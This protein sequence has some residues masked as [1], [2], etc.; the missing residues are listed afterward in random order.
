MLYLWPYMLFFSWPIIAQSLLQG[1]ISVCKSWSEIPRKVLLLGTVTNAAMA[2]IHY[3]T[4]V[5]PFTLADNRHYTFYVFRI[6][7][8]RPEIKYLAAPIYVL[9]AYAV[10][11]ALGHKPGPSQKRTD[12]AKSMRVS[13]GCKAS[14]VL[15][16]LITTALS[17]VTA[18]LVEPRYCILPWMMWRIHVPIGAQEVIENEKAK[19]TKNVSRET[20]WRSMYGVILETVWFLSLAIGTGYMFL[21]RGFAWP[22][23]PGKVQRFMW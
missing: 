17:L 9:S 5:H 23:E 2:V 4:I 20:R 15:V 21:Y 8:R 22:Q 12:S 13:S 16:W 1:N 3:N 14:F 18:P 6:L 7:L 10:I 19:K 11:Q